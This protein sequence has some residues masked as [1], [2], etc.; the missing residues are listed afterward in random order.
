[1]QRCETRVSSPEGVAEGTRN[2]R[3][4]KRRPPVAH[5]LSALRWGGIAFKVAG[6]RTE[7]WAQP[8]NRWGSLGA[9]LVAR[10]RAQ[11]SPKSANGLCLE[12]AITGSERASRSVSLYTA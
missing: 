9:R 12:Q 4:A 11:E 6:S 8:A 2:A 7:R 5:V 1:M 10:L 3:I